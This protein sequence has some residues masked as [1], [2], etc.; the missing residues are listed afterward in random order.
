ML[1]VLQLQAVCQAVASLGTNVTPVLHTK[2]AWSRAAVGGNPQNP[3]CGALSEVWD[4]GT[5][6]VVLNLQVSDIEVLEN[7]IFSICINGRAM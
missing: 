7:L 4:P 3:T 2:C 5:I 6:F 1:L